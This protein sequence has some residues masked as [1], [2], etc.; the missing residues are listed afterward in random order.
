M[1]NILS[2]KR[3]ITAA[4]NVSKTTKAMQ[5]IAA[6]KLKRGQDLAL[7]SRPYAD[8]LVQLLQNI[9]SKL[10]EK[11]YH[12]YMKT[13]KQVKSNLLIIFAPD[14]GLCGGLIGNI[15]DEIF[16]FDSKNPNTIYIT[17]GKKIEKYVSSLNKEIV[18]SFN[19]G[20]TRP[21]FDKVYPLITIINS[22]FQGKKVK[23]VKI[24]Y[25]KFLN[26]FSQQQEIAD[27]LPIEFPSKETAKPMSQTTIF[28]PSPQ[29]LLSPLLQHY[30]ETVIFHISLESYAS[31]QA[32]RMLSMQNATNNAIEI[33]NEI[34]L[35]YN[36]A[37][38]ERITNEILDISSATFTTIM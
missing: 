10:E 5:M 17:V 35:E 3:R 34:R 14:K 4:Q 31:E 19:F 27:L 30:L 24:L 2:L 23:S 7:K 12:D 8:K 36:K 25:S 32:A 6:S 11:F 22:F 9:V 13:P 21:Q 37:R 16:N 28:E 38:Q 20:T 26:V 33:T 1:A 15:I 29:I 18:A